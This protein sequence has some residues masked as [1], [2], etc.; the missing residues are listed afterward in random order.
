MSSLLHPDA[1]PP[2]LE[3]LAVSRWYGQVIGVNDISVRVSPGVTGLLGLNGA[4]KS[5]LFK[6]MAGQLKPSKGSVHVFGL[7]LNRNRGLYR[8]IGFVAEPD[9]LYESMTGREM[10]V[11]LTR[12]QGFTKSEAEDRTAQALERT[13]LTQD[14]DRSVRG[15]SKGMRQKIKMAQALAHEPDLLFLDEPFNGM[16]PT[17]RRESLELIHAL[18]EEGRTVM[19]SS[20]ILHEVEDMTS[21]IL[22]INRGRILAEGDIPEIRDALERQPHRIEVRCE[23]PR[24]L[25]A[26]LIE[27]E[28]I[29]GVQVLPAGEL[30][31]E[32]DLPRDLYRR[33]PELAVRDGQRIQ[34]W[35]TLDDNLKSL[36]EYLV[37]EGR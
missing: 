21:R 13:Q 32:S 18:G 2:V 10:L 8:R 15:Y 23:R 6:V 34:G 26:R 16:D 11:Y 12:L 4:G 24:D 3:T 33:L 36:F 5:T 25:A 17:S 20:H 7:D 9:A 29:Q 31:I 35:R 19:V 37:E 22:L 1:A 28:N 14:A 30:V 27:M